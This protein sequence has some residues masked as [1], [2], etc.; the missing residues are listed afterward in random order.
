MA[1][2]NV[3]IVDDEQEFREMTIKRLNKKDLQQ[4]VRWQAGGAHDGD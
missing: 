1:L 2:F 3:L 4:T